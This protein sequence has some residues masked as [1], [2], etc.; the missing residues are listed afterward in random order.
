LVFA[1]LAATLGAPL[2]SYG[3][4][5]HFFRI[6]LPPG[7][8]EVTP[9]AAG[10]FV[11][12]NRSENRQLTI[13]AFDLPRPMD[14]ATFDHFVSVRVEAERKELQGSGEVKI[15]EAQRT[16]TV[17]RVLFFVTE[18][19]PGR[20]ATGAITAIP[21]RVATFYLESVGGTREAHDA[22]AHA[23]LDSG[24]VR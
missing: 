17:Q 9:S 12:Q 11:Y 1:V 5:Q 7:W 6:S 3:V 4:E 8:V 13:S 19:Q 10:R 18:K 16:A 20:F 22:A 23:I 15:G 21:N 24:Q 14:V 2:E